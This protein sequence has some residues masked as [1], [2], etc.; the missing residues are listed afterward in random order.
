MVYHTPGPGKR[1][2]LAWIDKYLCQKWTGHKGETYTIKPQDANQ[3][4]AIKPVSSSWICTRSGFGP[5]GT[6]S[7]T[8][9]YDEGSRAVWWGSWTYYFDPEEIAQTPDVLSWYKPNGEKAIFEWW[10]EAS[11]QRYHRIPSQPKTHKPVDYAEVD[12]PEFVGGETNVDDVSQTDNEPEFVGGEANVD[13]VSQ[14]GNISSARTESFGD[15]P[16][17]S[18]AAPADASADRSAP[19]SIDAQSAET[20]DSIGSDI[21]SDTA[22]KQRLANQVKDWQKQSA[23]HKEAWHRFVKAN[24]GEN[25]YDPNRHDES[26]LMQFT[27]MADAGQIELKEP[28]R[29][30]IAEIDRLRGRNRGKGHTGQ[31]MSSSQMLAGLYLFGELPA[32]L[33]GCDPVKSPEAFQPPPGL[34]FHADIE[35]PPGLGPP[36]GLSGAELTRATDCHPAINDESTTGSGC[37]TTADSEVDVEPAENISQAKE[38]DVGLDPRG[39]SDAIFVF[40]DKNGNDVLEYEELLQCIVLMCS[41]TESEGRASLTKSAFG[42]MMAKLGGGTAMTKE[43]FYRKYAEMFSVKNFEDVIDKDYK[44]ILEVKCQVRANAKVVA[45]DTIRSTFG[46]VISPGD[47]GV[48]K[49]ID[50]RGDAYIRFDDG[51]QLCVREIDFCKFDIEV[52]SALEASDHFVDDAVSLDCIGQAKEK[53][54][55]KKQLQASRGIMGHDAGL[56]RQDFVHFQDVQAQAKKQT[57]SRHKARRRNSMQAQCR[58]DWAP[59]ER[60]QREQDTWAPSLNTLYKPSP[61]EG[62]WVDRCGLV[63]V[64][65]GK[66]LHWAHPVDNVDATD[67][68]LCKGNTI[69]IDFLGERMCGTLHGE[70]LWWSS[71]EVWWRVPISDR[72]CI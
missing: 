16:T 27:Q 28:T 42:E 71:E 70:E 38:T 61:L 7:F 48:V 60:S 8:L 69:Q 43:Q 59:L 19:E 30:K 68:V 25:N 6:K 11:S 72:L 46:A 51:R 62:T 22:E 49:Q 14:T 2:K 18:S 3:D 29:K 24:T 13:D 36:P 47:H 26:M 57:P 34:D 50:T 12:K 15:S 1:K 9:K 66:I 35:P 20:S 53:T 52:R 33:A 65:K 64:I 45:R 56:C 41:M 5:N 58:M 54:A 21:A 40:F 67:V 31:E 17:P 55:I 37:S 63:G 39:K 10:L 32:A 44:K 23:L 4:Y